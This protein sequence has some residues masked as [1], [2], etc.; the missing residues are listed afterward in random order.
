MTIVRPKFV[1]WSSNQEWRS[2]CAD[3]VSKTSQ[4]ADFGTE[5]N[6]ATWSG[7]TTPFKEE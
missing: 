1:H 2:I 4:I 3:T 7:I 6:T 5:K